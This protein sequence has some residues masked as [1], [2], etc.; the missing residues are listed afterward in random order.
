MVPAHPSRCPWEAAPASPPALLSPARG[1]ARG[2]AARHRI[3]W[4]R[5]RGGVTERPGSG[6]G[7]GGGPG[8]GRHRRAWLRPRW[9]RRAASPPLASPR[10]AS[11]GRSPPRRGG[12][13]PRTPPPGAPAPSPGRARGAPRSPSAR[14]RSSGRRRRPGCDAVLAGGPPRGSAGGKERELPGLWLTPW[15]PGGG[16]RR[17]GSLRS[18]AEP[19]DVPA[20]G[21]IILELARRGGRRT[22]GTAFHSCEEVVR[23]CCIGK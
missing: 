5:Q 6:G 20:P 23:R 16:A 2:R 7:A 18:S 17:P 19:G 8:R 4:R 21:G 3:W 10:L 1:P 15:A 11:P 14:R 22:S 9:R 12:A 13:A